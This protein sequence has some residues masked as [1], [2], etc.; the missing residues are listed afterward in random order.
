MAGAVLR[1]LAWLATQVWRFGV[2]VVN[3]VATWVRKNWKIVLR[4]LEAGA[5]FLWIVNEVKRLLGL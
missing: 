4:W 5:S 1:F 3:A 2:R